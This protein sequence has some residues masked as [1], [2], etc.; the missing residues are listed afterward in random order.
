MKY[1]QKTTDNFE[2]RIKAKRNIQEKEE[3][4][5]Y[6]MRMF[7]D[8]GSKVI[9]GIKNFKTFDDKNCRKIENSSAADTANEEAQIDNM[10]EKIENEL[11]ELQTNSNMWYVL[12]NILY[13]LNEKNFNIFNYI[14]IIYLWLIS[15]NLKS[16][17][18]NDCNK[19]ITK[20]YLHKLN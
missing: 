9:I 11:K 13:I 16:I 5:F 12:C 20:I 19:F 15:L 3:K 18:I 8:V 6:K 17:L 14:R 10:I 7:S 2:N 1:E 4:P